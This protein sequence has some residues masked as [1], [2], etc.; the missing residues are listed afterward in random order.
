MCEEAERVLESL[1]KTAKDSQGHMALVA[2]GN[3]WPTASSSWWRK[4]PLH[5]TCT[6]GQQIQTAAFQICM[7]PKASPKS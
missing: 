6:Q 3:T 7:N 1:I 5:L 4:C 2:T